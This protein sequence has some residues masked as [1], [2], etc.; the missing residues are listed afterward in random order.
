MKIQKY[1]LARAIDCIKSVIVRNPAFPALE[2]IL[3][4]DGYFTG[5]NMELT[6]QV[7][8]EACGGDSFIIPGRAFDAIKALPDG[9]VEVTVE[10]GKTDIVTIRTGKTRNRYQTFPVDAFSFYKADAGE[11]D[12][13][14]LPGEDFLRALM[15]VVNATDDKAQARIMAGVYIGSTDEGVNIC[16]TDSHIIEWDRL[17]MFCREK[18]EAIIPKSA[19][20]QLLSLGIEDDITISYDAHSIVFKGRDFKVSS[21]LIEGKYLDFVRFWASKGEIDVEVSKKELAEAMGR[22]KVCMYDLGKNRRPAVITVGSNQMEV[23]INSGTS[24]FY[25]ALSIIA[26]VAQPLRIGLN[27]VHIL[28][29]LKPFADGTVHLRMSGPSAPVYL[30][31]ENSLFQAMVLPV[32]IM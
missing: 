13:V 27:P 18:I 4:K 6:I 32:N 15:N 2:G 14:T 21:R 30:E 23:E 9:E 28:E 1:E 16:A 10:N 5:T 17:D 8:S 19:V 11:N 31:Q 22:A 25:E 20:K 26:S 29:C 3:V 7:F 24:D 12:G